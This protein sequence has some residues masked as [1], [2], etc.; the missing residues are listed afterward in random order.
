MKNFIQPGECITLTAPAGGVVSG[1]GYQIGQVFVVATTDAAVGARFEGCAVGVFEFPKVS[2]QAWTEGALIYWD[3]GAKN[4][5]TVAT[6][7]LCV[8]VATAVATNPSATGRVRLNGL[9]AA[10]AA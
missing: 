4:C 9:G 10:N 6:G 3:S 7:K 1:N 8:G 2:A 5:T